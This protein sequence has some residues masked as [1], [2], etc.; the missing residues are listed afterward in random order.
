MKTEDTI[1][2]TIPLEVEHIITLLLAVYDDLYW[3]KAALRVDC[4]RDECWV[5]TAG[6]VQEALLSLAHVD[7]DPTFCNS[8]ARLEDLCSQAFACIG[9]HNHS[10]EK[11]AK[12]LARI[13]TEAIDLWSKEAPELQK[14]HKES[15]EES[16][17]CLKKALQWD[18]TYEE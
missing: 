7:A 6:I 12:A 15:A 18:E 5:D 9:G 1:R 8:Q 11:R 17:R 4:D 3:L 2:S 10:P 13:R 14:R 16:L